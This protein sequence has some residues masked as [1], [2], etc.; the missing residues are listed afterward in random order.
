MIAAGCGSDDGPELTPAQQ[1]QAAAQAPRH[2]DLP[3][4]TSREALLADLRQTILADARGRRRAGEFDGPPFRGTHCVP[5]R[6]DLTYAR[7]HPDAPVL[8]YSCTAYTIAGQDHA[9]AADRQGGVR[10]AMRR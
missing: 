8:R 2:R 3:D 10:R 1:R 6:D 7:E 9:A 5:V 4:G